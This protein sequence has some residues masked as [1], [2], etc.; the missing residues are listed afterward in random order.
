MW[1]F[2]ESHPPEGDSLHCQR[3]EAGRVV[4]SA[5]GPSQLRRS[6]EVKR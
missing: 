1:V 2:G 6:A 3:R 5:P 4:T